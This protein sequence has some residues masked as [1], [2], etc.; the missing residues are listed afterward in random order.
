MT[1]T[2]AHFSLAQRG[3]VLD[4]MLRVRLLRNVPMSI[5]DVRVERDGGHVAFTSSSAVRRL[6]TGRPYT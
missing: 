3:G 4:A 6:E 1:Y 2:N 5:G